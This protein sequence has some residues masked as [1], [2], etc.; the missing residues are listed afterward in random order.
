MSSEDR[1]DFDAVTCQ[2]RGRPFFFG[3]CFFP[4]LLKC[5]YC[6]SWEPNAS[7]E[8]HGILIK[9]TNILVF[10]VYFN[11]KNEDEKMWRAEETW[12]NEP[13]HGRDIDD[14]K[15]P[16]PWVIRPS[17]DFSSAMQPRD[18]TP[19]SCN[20]KNQSHPSMTWSVSNMRPFSA[21]YKK[22]N[23]LNLG[24]Q[25]DLRAWHLGSLNSKYRG[26]LTPMNC[27]EM[28]WNS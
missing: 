20:L 28:T 21:I 19:V 16:P 25:S 24:S 26:W 3:V 27:M 22:K 15:M 4:M 6:R 7:L 13:V 11:S 2:D 23:A 9:K 8:V 12:M 14:E 5:F 10:G 17:C 1:K 18:H